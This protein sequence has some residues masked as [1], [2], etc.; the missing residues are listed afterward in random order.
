M[1]EE[2]QENKVTNQRSLQDYLS[3]GYLYLLILGIF[4]D[5]I[6]YGCLGV[7]I[8]NYSS[9]QDIL[10]SPIIHLTSDIKRFL[11]FFVG[12]PLVAFSI[13]YMAKKFHDNNRNKDWYRTKKNFEKWDRQY[14]EENFFNFLISV[15]LFALFGGFIGFGLGNGQKKAEKL[16]TQKLEMDHQ[17]TFVNEEQLKI[18]LL[19]HNSEYLFYAAEND[20]TVTIVPIQGNIKKIENLE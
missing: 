1:K 2:L 11:I 5:A 12:F 15:M 19:G 7:N 3:L 10:L 14:S 8:I 20:T 4:K 18:N 9:V 17:I 6:Y 13:G 16:S